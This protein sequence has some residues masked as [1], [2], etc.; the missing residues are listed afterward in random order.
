M[1]ILFKTEIRKIEQQQGIQG[2]R[3]QCHNRPRCVQKND[4]I[5]N[6]NYST[7]KDYRIVED[8]DYNIKHDL[9]TDNSNNS[10]NYNVNDDTEKQYGHTNY[11]DEHWQR[12]NENDQAVENRHADDAKGDDN[13]NHQYSTNKEGKKVDDY[14]YKREN[15]SCWLR[16]NNDDSR[17]DNNVDKDDNI[18]DQ[19]FDQKG[20]TG[21]ST[22]QR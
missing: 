16:N 12:R 7:Y 13:V 6:Q 14:S 10:N 1:K 20:N 5:A 22:N 8:E 21:Y 11:N 17:N 18:G 2:R 19:I 15:I 4:D 9:H 3:L